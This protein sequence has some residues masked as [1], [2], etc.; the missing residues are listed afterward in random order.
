MAECARDQPTSRPSDNPVRRARRSETPG[1]HR[2]AEGGC[3]IPL[4]L[5][6]A[7]LSSCE[8]LGRV[9]QTYSGSVL[10]S[11]GY[12]QGVMGG[13]NTSPDYV[14]TM[15]L[16]YATWASLRLLSPSC[17]SHLMRAGT[18]AHLKDM[19]Q[20]SRSLPSKEAL[21][22][23]TISE[24]FLDHLWEALLV[25]GK[26]CLCVYRCFYR[27]RPQRIGRKRS[28]MLA[29]AWVCV[30]AALQ[31]SAQ[32]AAWM[33]C[34]RLVNGIGT[35]C[36]N[37]VVPVWSAE[38][39]THTSRGAFIASEFTLNIFGV[40]IAY[41]LEFGLGFVGDGNTQVRWRVSKAGLTLRFLG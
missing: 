37:A 23:Y 16:G 33:L 31:C 11:F 34:A 6:P 19:L 4:I 40:V 36:L 10:H 5:L 8:S 7:W 26:L 18:P 13:V 17:R 20:R 15:G 21:S 9:V 35:G 30:G 39:A 3:T 2:Y 1:W 22:A 32:N 41:W 24:H 28:M 12:D 38:V 25:T 14:T 27:L 29:A